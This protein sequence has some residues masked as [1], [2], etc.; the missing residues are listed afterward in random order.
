MMISGNSLLS[1]FALSGTAASGVAPRQDQQE[2]QPAASASL[3]A[4]PA[5]TTSEN[6]SD[7]TFGTAAANRAGSG[8]ASRGTPAEGAPTANAASAP[9]STTE[10]IDLAIIARARTLVGASEAENVLNDDGS[11]NY[12]KLSDLLAEQ[13]QSTEAS[14][15]RPTPVVD[16]LA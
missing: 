16:L 6:S 10:T 7:S 2:A 8:A 13:Q 11:L 12:Q 5:I 14:T 15:A 1:P 4:A 3:A 9:A